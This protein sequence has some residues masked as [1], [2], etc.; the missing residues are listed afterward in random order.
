[1]SELAGWV[2]L[3][4]TQPSPAARNT[5]LA[6]A[7]ALRAGTPEDIR[8]WEGPGAVIAVRPS[9]AATGAGT[10]RTVTLAA[11]RPAENGG[12]GTAPALAGAPAD[13]PRARADT[14]AL[15]GNRFSAA[16]AHKRGRADASGP[17]VE[18]D[19]L[20]PV[21][22]AAFAGLCDNRAGL[23]PA[24]SA[25]EAVARAWLTSGPA[26]PARLRGSYALAVWQ[27]R[28]RELTLARDHL[29]TRPL[30]WARTPTG[31]A[32]ASR[33][34]A[35]FAHPALRARLDGD[36]LRLVLSGISVPGRT[37]FADVYEVPAAHT[38]TFT[39]AGR[40]AR[41]YW[42]PEAAGH[43]HDADATAVHV[44]ELLADAVAEQSG[45]A[46]VRVGSLLSGGLDSSALAALLAAR[47]DGPLPTFAVDYQGYEENFRPHIVRPRPDSP[48]VRDMAAHLGSAH[49]D[50]VLT[51]R[52]LTRPAVWT[53]LVEELDQPRLFADTEPSMSLLYGAV[54]GRAD[55]LLGGEGAD[56]LFGGFPWFHHPR[57]AQAPD[58][59]W[60][61][62][63]DELVGTLFG[64][65][66]KELD[67]RAFR[68]DHYRTA[69]AE[70]PGLPG[71]D[72]QE[73]RMR[74]LAYLFTTRFLPEQLDRAHRFGAATGIDVRLP[75]CDPRLVEYALNIPWSVKTADGHEKSPLRAAVADLLPRSVLER[76]KSGYP[77]THDDGYDD[78]LRSR[79]TALPPDA[80]VR[81]LLATEAPRFSRTELEL[82]LKLNAWLERYGLTLP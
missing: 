11:A 25:G 60:T 78:T 58:F 57:W 8:L 23:P 50:V 75:F 28:T 45:H 4:G 18:A 47:V 29:G 3:V 36:A 5:V 64:P 43:P 38:V 15:K 19:S 42:H 22:V 12:P 46:G 71:E 7:R 61:P 16:P 49:T 66:L 65:A 51:T 9:P 69:L 35:L 54:A 6:M 41:R 14:P 55:L 77:M 53:R 67:V 13:S 79:L 44:R 76:R 74:E 68:A 70:L 27:P 62:T 72:P 17:A 21:A 31:V 48:F 59:P 82:A 56:E 26:T 32:F 34:D 39:P 10:A 52:D 80:P 33:P 73:R 2:D 63:T 1:M 30:Y 40:T 37:V 24:S 20:G 81:P